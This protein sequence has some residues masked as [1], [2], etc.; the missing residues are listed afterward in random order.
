MVT[1]EKIE[2]EHVQA[3]YNLTLANR[4]H[5]REWLPWLDAMRSIEDTER[6]VQSKIEAFTDHG[7]PN[8]IILWDGI[9]CGLAGFNTINR[10]NNIGALGYWLGKPYV[11]NGIMTYVVNRLLQLAFNE[12]NLNRVEIRCATENNKSR[13]IPERLGFT[14]EGTLRQCEWLYTHYVDHVVYALLAADYPH[15][16]STQ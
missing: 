16:M 3:L 12:L 14:Q 7:V 8:Y 4:D 5:L 6:F 11:G 2:L 15:N 10:A 9:I 1:L 13:A